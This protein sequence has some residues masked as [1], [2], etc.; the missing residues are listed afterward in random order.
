MDLVSS[1]GIPHSAQKS[2]S[3]NSLQRWDTFCLSRDNHGPLRVV[4]FFLFVRLIISGPNDE[5]NEDA[6]SDF[7]HSDSGSQGFRRSSPSLWEQSAALNE[8]A[9]PSKSRCSWMSCN[10]TNCRCVR[11]KRG[12]LRLM[13]YPSKN[14]PIYWWI[15]RWIQ[16]SLS[17]ESRRT[18]SS[19][20]KPRYVF[21]YL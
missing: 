6:D 1:Q 12:A 17:P 20:F 15:H 9:T 5:D 8:E 21:C 2:V 18:P 16:C 13:A 19:L 3:S 11:C 7:R 14:T 10:V 4:Q